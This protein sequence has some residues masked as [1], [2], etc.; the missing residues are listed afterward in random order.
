MENKDKT[1]SENIAATT[2]QETDA[3][4]AE[5]TKDN[6]PEINAEGAE[7]VD[8]VEEVKD[9][10][11]KNVDEQAA[12]ES[13]QN[14][15][16]NSATMSYAES[17]IEAYTAPLNTSDLENED[18]LW[19]KYKDKYVSQNAG[20]EVKAK[21]Q[22]GEVYKAISQKWDQ[23]AQ[24]EYEGQML[25]NVD[26]LAFGTEDIEYV[27]P[28]IATQVELM[29]K[30][31]S[32]RMQIMG[33]WTDPTRSVREAAIDSKKVIDKEGNVLEFEEDPYNEFV[34]KDEYSDKEGNQ[35][36]A[37]EYE[38]GDEFSRGG[39]MLKAIYEGDD[40]TTEVV[41]K[42]DTSKSWAA[43]NIFSK[44]KLDTSTWKVMAGSVTDFVVD[45]A[46]TA[47]SL[48]ENAINL[49]TL[50]A[51]KDTDMMTNLR[52][53][54]VQLASAKTSSSDYD[55]SKMVTWNNFVNLGMTVGLQLAY[56]RGIAAGMSKMLRTGKKAADKLGVMRKD[57]FDIER[58]AK[59]AAT[60]GEAEALKLQYFEKA[61]QLAQASHTF[62]RKAN[63]IKKT[64]LLAMGAMQAKETADA[65]RKAGFNE[66]QSAMIYTTSLG[67]MS[68]ANQLSDLGFERLGLNT[69]T[70]VIKKAVQDGMR[71]ITPATTNAIPKL[72]TNIAEKGTYVK[73]QIAGMLG[74]QG[75]GLGAHALS[76]AMEEEAE[77]LADELVRNAASA[78]SVIGY[79]P[80]SA[81]RFQTIFD[82]GYFDRFFTESA[83]NMFGGAL[84][85]SMMGVGPMLKARNT[86]IKED[87]LPY[88]GDTKSVMKHIGYYATRTATG[89]QQKAEFMSYAD[90]MH[91]KG[92]LGRHDL[93][94][95]WNSEDKRYYRMNEL[96]EDERK[97]HQSHA[98]VQYNALIQQLLYY[99]QAYAIEPSASRDAV[100][101]TPE[102][103]DTIHNEMLYEDV[104]KS[105]ETRADILTQA[106]LQDVQSFDQSISD[107]RDMREDVDEEGDMKHEDKY[108]KQMEELADASGLSQEQIKTLVDIDEQM[109]AVKT[110][111][112][113][114]TALIKANLHDNPKYDKLDFDKLKGIV[115]ADTHARDKAT[116]IHKENT[117]KQQ[118]DSNAILKYIEEKKPTLEDLTTQITP[119]TRLS[120]EAKLAVLDYVNNYDTPLD[121]QKLTI[122]NKL[123]TELE[124]LHKSSPYLGK[125]FDGMETVH[126]F[127]LPDGRT[128]LVALREAIDSGDIEAVNQ[129]M[130]LIDIESRDQSG[131]S[132][133]GELLDMLENN[134]EE[135]DT[136]KV[137]S[138]FTKSR[139]LMSKIN[140]VLGVTS[141]S[142]FDNI[143]FSVDN[144]IDLTDTDGASAFD[145][146]AAPQEREGSKKLLETINPDPIYKE[147][148]K[149]KNIIESVITVGKYP[150]RTGDDFIYGYTELPNNKVKADTAT[151][152]EQL[153][154]ITAPFE[155]ENENVAY[156]P[157]KEGITKYLDK[158]DAR[159]QQ[160][161][162]VMDFMPQLNEIRALNK[163]HFK[164]DNSP[165]TF[166][167]SY[168]NK[169]IISFDKWQ[170]APDQVMDILKQD[171]DLLMGWKSL[172]TKLSEKADM[173]SED[174]SKIYA[175]DG[176]D[177]IKTRVELVR[178][179]VTSPQFAARLDQYPHLLEA[180]KIANAM[181]RAP[182]DDLTTLAKM[183]DDL[184]K[185]R[186]LIALEAEENADFI[187][188]VIEST[189]SKNDL[190]KLLTMIITPTDKIM[191]MIKN[192][193]QQVIDAGTSDPETWKKAK[194]PMF[195][196]IAMAEEVVA[197]TVYIKGAKQGFLGLVMSK[198]TSSETYTNMALF[199]GRLGTGKTQVVAGIAA[200]IIQE[201][202]IEDAGGD[203]KNAK[204]IML[205]ANNDGQVET[206]KG[207]VG[208][209]VKVTDTMLQEDLWNLTANNGDAIGDI[210]KLFDNT[211]V[212][213]YDEMSQVEFSSDDQFVI[214][215]KTINPSNAK[216]I[217]VLNGILGKITQINQDRVARGLKPLVVI[218]LGDSRQGGFMEGSISPRDPKGSEN[219]GKLMN[220]Y[221]LSASIYASDIVL[222]HNF[223]SS[224]R[225]LSNAVNMLLDNYRPYSNVV[226]PSTY[227]WNHSKEDGYT[228][229]RIASSWDN[230]INDADLI[231]DIESRIE[232]TKDSDNK[233]KVIV[234]T[235]LR[236]YDGSL[237]KDE[238]LLGKLIKKYPDNFI[239]KGFDTVQ[240]L[241]ADYSL[242]NVPD[243]FLPFTEKEIQETA[244][245]SPEDIVLFQNRMRQISMA[246]GR[247]KQFAALTFSTDFP[248]TSTKQ[249]DT[250][251]LKPGEAAEFRKTWAKTLNEGVLASYDAAAPTGVPITEDTKEITEDNA[252]DNYTNFAE[253]YSLTPGKTKV[254]RVEAPNVLYTVDTVEGTDVTMTIT[255]EEQIDQTHPKTITISKDRFDSG[256]FMTKATYDEWKD[257]EKD[258]K[259]TVI[260]VKKLSLDV[261]EGEGVLDSQQ[262]GEG[263]QLTESNTLIDQ[264]RQV[265]EDIRDVVNFKEDI[266]DE[267]LNKLRKTLEGIING[268]GR[269]YSDET[270]DKAKRALTIVNE[271][272]DTMLGN[273]KGEDFIAQDSIEGDFKTEKDKAIDAEI[274]GEVITYSHTAKNETEK[275]AIKKL[276]TDA[277]KVLGDKVVPL[278]GLRTA[279]NAAMGLTS[280][281]GFITASKGYKYKIITFNVA[282]KDIVNT[283]VFAVKN[284]EYIPLVQL[285]TYDSYTPG[286]VGRVGSRGTMH[287]FLKNRK[288][289]ILEGTDATVKTTT[290]SFGEEVRFIESTIID[291]TTF[292]NGTTVGSLVTSNKAV[293]GFTLN[294]KWVKDNVDVS[295]I[296]S[297]RFLQSRT[298]L[299]E[300]KIGLE[301]LN[302][303]GFKNY[304]PKEGVTP[305][306]SMSGDDKVFTKLKDGREFVSVTTSRNAMVFHKVGGFWLPVLG[307]SPKGVVYTMDKK[308]LKKDYELFTISA[309]LRELSLT[310]DTKPDDKYINTSLEIS[311]V[312]SYAN[313]S[314]ELPDSAWNTIP[315]DEDKRIHVD[316][317]RWLYRKFNA[318]ST[319]TVG[320]INLPLNIAKEMWATQT[321]GPASTSAVFNINSGPNAGKSVIFYTFRE[322]ID[323]DSMSDEEILT[324]YNA[325]VQ[326]AKKPGAP[327]TSTNQKGIGM[328]LLDPPG[329]TFSSA[330]IAAHNNPIFTRK[331]AN[332]V[333]MS[334]KAKSN[335]LSLFSTLQVLMSER[336]GEVPPIIA[337]QLAAE[338]SQASKEAIKKWLD[339]LAENDP[340]ALKFIGH[341]LADIFTIENT[342]KIVVANP[343]P[344]LSQMIKDVRFE[345]E[346]VMLDPTIKL[347]DQPKE[348]EIRLDKLYAS[349]MEDPM[350]KDILNRL[351][352]NNALE[353]RS[354]TERGANTAG[355][356]AYNEKGRL[357]TSGYKVV[358][359]LDKSLVKRL[360]NRND[361]KPILPADDFD[362]MGLFQLFDDNIDTEKHRMYA[363]RFLDQLIDFVDGFEYGIFMSPLSHNS[364]STISRAKVTK[365]EDQNLEVYTTVKQIKRPG[366]V[367]NTA[368]DSLQSHV[369]DDRVED[370]DPDIRKQREQ[371]ERE[372]KEA[373]KRKTLEAELSNVTKALTVENLPDMTTTQFRQAK[374]NFN[375]TLGKMTNNHKEQFKDIIE[376]TEENIKEHS[377]LFKRIPKTPF[378]SSKLRPE[379]I[380]PKHM[381]LKNEDYD[382][383]MDVLDFI[384]DTTIIGK[385]VSEYAKNIFIKNNLPKLNAKIRSRIEAYITNVYAFSKETPEAI[386]TVKTRLKE[387]M[388]GTGTA[389]NV[390]VK[391][392]SEAEEQLKN[393]INSSIPIELL[394]PLDLLFSY[395]IASSTRRGLFDV[396]AENKGRAMDIL[397]SNYASESVINDS[398]TALQE[399]VNSIVSKN[400]TN[401]Q[402]ITPLVELVT[403]Y[404]YNK[405]VKPEHLLPLLEAARTVAAD[406]NARTD[407]DDAAKTN[408]NNE[409]ARIE[410][411]IEEKLTELGE[412]VPPGTSPVEEGVVDLTTADG[413]NMEFTSAEYGYDALPSNI[414]EV[415]TDFLT[416]DENELTA[417]IANLWNPATKR[418]AKKAMIE[419][420]K[421]RGWNRAQNLGL[422]MYINKVLTKLKDPKTDKTCKI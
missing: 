29:A 23:Q 258:Q 313:N 43:K 49:T 141:S 117:A 179:L 104:A 149:T 54:R 84:G 348:I 304:K 263:T 375:E 70:G 174:L 121:A 61:A 197:S 79:G 362:I 339:D 175:K 382:I 15:E 139:Y 107:L 296:E 162:F 132:Q 230:I 288:T 217:P 410:K 291:P 191:G 140:S 7:G 248:S 284:G 226:M 395:N 406:V 351:S 89:A 26:F 222:T 275:A 343:D 407:V 164:A 412:E 44:N 371:E 392:V 35:I 203:V 401:L 114:E 332:K 373:E 157:D 71:G 312:T 379:D 46:D 364:A 365:S 239:L 112:I 314:L 192:N 377:K 188:R 69:T 115:N 323:L 193:I 250:S 297:G 123:L 128:P 233:F 335:M 280:P 171:M 380:I 398:I 93:S 94:T 345:V 363:L 16:N 321:G 350:K 178:S 105:L 4:V 82:E 229:A 122:A 285:S 148:L 378:S 205:V 360:T 189:S 336:K 126:E 308:M 249:A 64:T 254:L 158:V 251:V 198:T 274:N 281:E 307:I 265:L 20:D 144:I 328:I 302:K 270:I 131:D 58:K 289:R 390:W 305:F 19:E 334:G 311:N 83:M 186:K 77:F 393:L 287:D 418:E 150:D 196:Q 218:G 338:H 95:K 221:T 163:Q 142:G 253:K 28:E 55:Q 25:E 31:D 352:I 262:L 421:A 227:I 273:I 244:T 278:T 155:D 306:Q 283:M 41:S 282:G 113:L 147:R 310:G 184:A 129:T 38:L 52:S 2:A 267:S 385:E 255:D 215:S 66:F 397:T 319:A 45:V 219:T 212:I 160:L 68:W 234:V 88:Q 161:Q 60:M 119:E 257:A 337:T 220:P 231:N 286:P 309:L 199:E 92:M 40:P 320:N 204:G 269:H 225:E 414:Q 290:D 413:I 3:V 361:V 294:N 116:D 256:E 317:Q 394:R 400:P 127:V 277:S 260:K 156:F 134:G 259:R 264:M 110:G 18:E 235:G 232:A 419:L 416:Q 166:L 85:G 208:K 80:E 209:N 22:F 78:L 100:E 76:E 75:K 246:V 417:M 411:M 228:G 118:A 27:D 8:N 331:A 98:D 124:S 207:A 346:G 300:T 130:E 137:A 211:D 237:D 383:V 322:D 159:I 50:G 358:R 167:T 106:S 47:L 153:K 422:Q 252:V 355:F 62:N 170:A 91:K 303:E 356:L 12:Q 90:K 33:D 353:L 206:L 326:N 241:E 276:H 403:D 165:L 367:I 72:L 37:F 366:L 32:G 151:L 330:Y 99:E 376:Q 210:A 391:L 301:A 136:D 81:P 214:D 341:V 200:E 374:K 169:Y 11:G 120:E 48:T 402:A 216:D 185:I 181:D 399:Y 108:K 370:S 369:I 387:Y 195:S 357:V 388:E 154:A 152:G 17:I 272:K 409:L 24:E 172:A 138:A 146:N 36:I 329:R 86:P 194:V 109:N 96:T 271:L 145:V 381:I 408:V 51:L 316:K 34:G 420:G 368:V 372:R 261:K 292:F 9:N 183:A 30:T 268:S 236:R 125:I 266:N 5:Q 74:S 340:D 168:I 238:S 13:Q 245:K 299:A 190:A 65:A 87:E 10:V 201:L 39:S 354:I 349:F 347:E 240:G 59:R 213:I 315:K 327:L 102:F 404:Y 359:A 73:N 57:L 333:L 325:I 247:A 63:I 389:G 42:W 53:S 342:G 135:F 386:E 97:K 298:I 180:V 224:V 243:G 295:G 187:K 14:L 103:L 202:A 143:F 384:A 396:Q 111:S 176:I 344:D 173:A 6:A 133:V 318:R 223:R 1:L 242:V 101:A 182:T 324:N 415:I 56:G 67:L 405:A 279:A 177:Y 293:D 21:E